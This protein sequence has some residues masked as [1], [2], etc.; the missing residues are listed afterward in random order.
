M[1]TTLGARSGFNL[2]WKSIFEIIFSILKTSSSH[3]VLNRVNNADYQII[4]NQFYQFSRCKQPLWTMWNIHSWETRRWDL[5]N[6]CVIDRINIFSSGYSN[7]WASRAV[8][9]FTSTFTW[10]ISITKILLD[11]SDFYVF[12]MF[13]IKFLYPFVA[14][15]W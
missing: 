13:I 3:A 15:Y 11:F 14:S 12:M 4:K 2:C 1:Q 10:F 5:V 7:Y 6:L 9:I 8:L